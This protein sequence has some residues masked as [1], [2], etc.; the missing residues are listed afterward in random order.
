M[1]VEAI[2][3]ASGGANADAPFQVEHK[4]V[5]EANG[6]WAQSE[7]TDL[8]APYL[9]LDGQVR[10]SGRQ[11]RAASLDHVAHVLSG[12]HMRQ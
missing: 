5:D 8:D 7:F 12:A 4:S 10:L 2:G 3:V 1:L 11:W 9:V 6:L